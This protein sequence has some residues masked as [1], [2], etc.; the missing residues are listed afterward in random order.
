[1]AEIWMTKKMTSCYWS[2]DDDDG[3]LAQQKL[4]KNSKSFML[5]T[6]AKNMFAVENPLV[7][8]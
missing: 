8:F 5:P 6:D 4:E 7:V 2:F 1:M 3:P